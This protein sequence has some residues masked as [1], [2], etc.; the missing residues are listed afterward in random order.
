MKPKPDGLNVVEFTLNGVPFS[1]RISEGVS[2]MEV[3]REQ[4]GLISPKNGCAPQ[5]SCGCCTVI[6]GDKAVSSCAVPAKNVVGK[7]VWTLEGLNERERD[8]FAKA[9]SYSAGLQCGFCIPGIVIRAKHLIQKNP[10]P[11][12]EDIA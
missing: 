9:F 4:A 5:G 2:L 12:R 10:N 7:S 1:T 3:L 11:T 8:V 6:V